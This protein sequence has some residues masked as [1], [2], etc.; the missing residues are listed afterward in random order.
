MEERK[1]KDLNNVLSL[2]KEDAK[3]ILLNSIDIVFD[4]DSDDLSGYTLNYEDLGNDE[5]LI[6]DVVYL[7]SNDKYDGASLVEEVIADNGFSPTSGDY[8]NIY[9]YFVRESTANEFKDKL[10]E[11]IKSM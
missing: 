7:A 3:A 5:D 2:K 8:T 9:Y 1:I 11:K 4:E 6:A 10:I